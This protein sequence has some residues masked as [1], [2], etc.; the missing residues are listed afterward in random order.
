M[1]VVWIKQHLVDNEQSDLGGALT[2][3]AKVKDSEFN[4]AHLT[5]TDNIAGN[6]G[7]IQDWRFSPDQEKTYLLMV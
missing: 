6:I 4:L 3:P 7:W 2:P 5:K 1:V